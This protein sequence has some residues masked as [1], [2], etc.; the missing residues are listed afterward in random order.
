MTVILWRGAAHSGKL[1]EHFVIW[2]SARGAVCT[3]VP[4]GPCLDN[5]ACKLNDP[6][7]EVCLGDRRVFRHGLADLNSII[8][9]TWVC[10]SSCRPASYVCAMFAGIASICSRFINS[11]EKNTMHTPSSFVWAAAQRLFSIDRNLSK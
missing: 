9:G 7:I 3:C 5:S 1:H 6:A 2:Q 4:R 11:W 8:K 10:A